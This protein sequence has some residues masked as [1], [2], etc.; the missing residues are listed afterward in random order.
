MVI[1]AMENDGKMAIQGHYR[2]IT[3]RSQRRSQGSHTCETIWSH[4]A[5][6][7]WLPIRE[8]I[9]FKILVITRKC[10]HGLSPNYLSE[11][12]SCYVPNRP[13]RSQAQYKLKQSYASGSKARFRDRAFQHY[14]PN[15]WNILP[16]HAR[17]AS[18]LDSFETSIKTFLFNRAFNQ[19]HLL[20]L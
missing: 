14:A 16:V 5:D 8:R 3:A 18:S 13:L 15:I 12:V 11:L 9:D 10:L 7:H 6:L 20:T 1:F 17:S 4:N 2:E 19:W